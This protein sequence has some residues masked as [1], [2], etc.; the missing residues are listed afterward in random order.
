MN[1]EWKIVLEWIGYVA[2]LIVLIS[3]LMSSIKKLRWINLLGSA[4]F[5]VYG[6]FI[7]S[8]PVG[9]MNIGIAA[10]NIYYLVKMY[11]SSDFFK[12]LPIDTNT[13]YLN[14]F[15]S[16]YKGNISQYMELSIEKINNADISFFILR[17]MLPAGIFVCSKH[18]EKT[19]K[20]ELDYV[21][22]EFQDFKIG[23]FVFETQKQYFLEQGYSRF[24]FT[25]QNKKHMNYLRKMG[26]KE[27][28]SL[29]MNCYLKTIE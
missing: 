1:L 19:L 11:R 23:N 8:L 18:N 29:G 20:I 27:D 22:P 12:V 24:I 28:S 15:L 5:G 6:F 7:G 25:T 9:F 16:F 2:S 17:N 10:I 21:V 4:I 13:K 26:F 3:L 14:Y